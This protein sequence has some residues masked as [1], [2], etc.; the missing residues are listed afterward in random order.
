MT[1]VVGLTGGIGSGKSTVAAAFAAREVPVVDTD[2]IARWLT[3]PGT[4]A[5]VAI[6]DALGSD[7]RTPEGSL[8]RRLLRERVFADPDARATLERIV[9]PEIASAAR[10]AIATWVAPYGIVVV[11]LLLERGGLRDVVDRILVVDCPEGEQVRRAMARSAPFRRRGP[12]DHGHA[13]RAGGAPL[14]SAGRHR[15][16]GCRHAAIGPQIDTLDRRYRALSAARAGGSAT[17]A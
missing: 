8:D 4:P 14:R 17:G 13:T 9:H 1:L 7:L 10:R 16:L 15:Q 6:L 2:E 11:P 3:E 12:G 5:F